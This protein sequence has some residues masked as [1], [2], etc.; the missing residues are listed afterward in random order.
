M[1]R[2]F[3]TQREINFINDIAKELVKD[4]IGQKIYFFPIS[5]VKSNIHDIYEESPD[6]VFENPIELDALVKYDPQE[7]RTNRFGSEEYFTIEVYVHAKDL[8]DKEIEVLE[9]DFF[10]YGTVFFEIIKAPDTTTIFGQVE[11]KGY[12]TITG[13]QSRKGQFIS[14]VFG[15]TD[16]KYTDDDAIQDTFVQQRGKKSNR[17]GETG[18]VRELQKRGILDAPITGPKEVSS[19]GDKTGSGSSFYDEE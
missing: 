7:V 10:S 9:G 17:L 15:P 19:K 3:I 12:L 2:F 18:D 5:E 16:E 1:S 11:H 13:K 4:V 8:L 14:K 6:K